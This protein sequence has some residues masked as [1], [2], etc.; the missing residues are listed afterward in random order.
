[1]ISKQMAKIINEQ[2]NKEI[3]SAYLYQSMS[4]YSMFKGLHGTASWF[5][6]QAKEELGHATKFYKYLLEQNEQVVLDKI[7]KPES[8]FKGLKEM[9]E[10]TLAHEK[11][12]T[13]SINN[14]VALAIKENDYASNIFLQWFVTEQ[15]EEEANAVEIL[16]KVEII[17]ESGPAF[18]MLYKEL[19][20]RAAAS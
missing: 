18:Y 9:F 7:D 10:K 6:V 17:G 12:V 15:V 16:T 4:A 3:Y 11:I 1:M 5:Q 14:I 13:G 2:I 20:A 8:D 19:G